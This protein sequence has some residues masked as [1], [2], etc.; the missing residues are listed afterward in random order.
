MRLR[1][2]SRQSDSIND[3]FVIVGLEER[4]GRVVNAV[5]A[6]EVGRL[7]AAKVVAVQAAAFFELAGRSVLSADR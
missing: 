5:S 3:P 1:G 4:Q 6:F 7:P 2:L